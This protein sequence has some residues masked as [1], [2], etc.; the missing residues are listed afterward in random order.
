VGYVTTEGAF[1]KQEIQSYLQTK[2][3]EYMVP[4][5]WVELTTIPLTTNG[6]VDRKALPEPELTDLSKTYTAPSNETEQALASTW[7]ELLGREH[8]GIYD[9][10]FEIGGHSLLAMR[11]VSAIRKALNVEISVRDIFEH[12][13][14]AALGRHLGEQAKGTL[15]PAITSEERPARIPLSFSQERLWFIDKLEGS[16]QYHLPSVLRLRGEVN[17]PAL[18]TT[19][20]RIIE[21]HEVLRTVILADEQGQGYQQVMPAEGWKLSYEDQTQAAGNLE[22]HLQKL[23]SAPFDLSADYMLRAGLIRLGRDEYILAATMHH[24][25]SD[26]WSTSILVKEVVAL[27]GAYIEDQPAQLEALPIQYADYAIWQRKYMQGELLEA[28]LNYWKTKLAATAPLQLPCDNSRPAM[29]SSRGATLNFH[30]DQ[31]L[32]AK[33]GALS[34]QHGATLY[35]TLL[36]VFKVLLYRYSGQEDICV[37]TPIAG[38]N[39]HEVEGLI[40]FF[41]NTL[42]LRDQ[43]RGEDSF[44]VLLDQ[45]KETTLEAYAHQEVPFEKVVDAVVKDRDLG[46]HPLFQVMFVLQNTPEV[47]ELKLG[48]LQLASEGHEQRTTQFD[49]SFLLSETGTGLVG[50]VEYATDLYGED[51]IA[52]MTGHYINLLNSVAAAPETAAGKLSMLSVE[53]EAALNKFNDTKSAYPNDKHII[54]LFEE[55]AAQNPDAVA[56]VFEEENLTYKALNERSNQLARYLQKR[57]V[58]A[59]TLVPIC[60]ERSLE[61]IIGILGILKA[62]GAYVPIDPE[63]PQDRINYMLEDTEAELM[64]SSRSGRAKLNKGITIIALDGDGEAI[65]KEK[66]GNLETVISADQLAYVIYT[67]GSTGRPKGVMIEHGSLL[68]YCLTFK[69][70][71]AISDKDKILQQSSVSF[72]TMVEEVYPGLISG[73]SMIIVKEGGRDIYTLRNKIENEGISILSSTPTVIDWLNKELTT[74]GRLRYIISGGEVLPPHYINNLYSKVPIVNTYG[75]SESTVCVTYNKIDELASASLIGKPIANTQV[76]I[77]NKENELA[78]MG[79]TGEL[80]VGGVQVARGYLNNPGLT[81]EKFIKDPFS[82]E[83]GAKL[84]RTGD[85]AKW[86]PDGTIVYQGR[87]DDQVKIRGYRIELGE[88]ESV[89]N[90]HNNIRQGVV[91][92]KADKQGNNRLI[93]YVVA[94]GVF[95]KQAIQTFLNTRLPEYMVP[96]IWVELEAI[97]L[98]PNGKIDRKALPDPDLTAQPIEY[99]APRNETEQVLAAIWQELL[100]V[101]QVGIYDNFFELGGYSLLAM[102]VVSA[103]RNVL[104][105]EINVRDIFVN[106]SIAELATHLKANNKKKL[107]A[108]TPIKTSGNKTPLYIICGAGG[109]VFKFREFANLLDQDQ[110]VYGLQQF[111]DGED[112]DEF[113]DTI[114][115]VAAEYIEEIL[116]ENPDGPYALSG[117]CLGGTIAFEMANQ[118]KA[119]GKKV[120]LLAMFDAN[121]REQ[122]TIEEQEEIRPSLKN[123]YFIPTTIKAIIS[124]ISVKIRFELFLLIKHPKVAL[125]YKIRSIPPLF[126]YPE[127]AQEIIDKDVFD[128]LTD[129]L[130]RALNT[131]ELK[132]YYGEIL[133]FNAMKDYFFVDTENKILYKELPVNHKAKLAW[134]KHAESI[135]SYDVEGEH[136]TIFEPENASNFAEILQKHLNESSLDNIDVPKENAA[137]SKNL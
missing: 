67:S 123:F 24:I 32:S 91:V 107:R 3:P 14:I 65:N 93:G 45:V 80:C 110:P 26:G 133:L 113:P 82:S 57:G 44:T 97:P 2:L 108:L 51:T 111:I 7:Q 52:R 94:E 99:T 50:T 129:K 28:K 41:I 42:V 126:A 63:Y 137:V 58:K 72:D 27:Y 18:E 19:L 30:I 64:I 124:I 128:K 106:P 4:Q 33:L 9:N 122:H 114:E 43:V 96:A 38:R 84:Y 115:G 6:K 73:A 23:I 5:I 10:F 87:I 48:K 135:K 36:S 117:H 131:Y 15:L 76:Y 62:G 16:V 81:S 40:G 11:V 121:V 13:T 77:L 12:G 39:R 132:S 25:A 53:E 118:L 66:T 34:H 49:I 60:V 120:T 86:Q 61:M 56:I 134:K 1:D 74:T 78:P 59:E 95:D 20:Q 89:L 103:I 130:L 98:T 102:R 136:S 116:S 83:P 21:R 119:K 35:M 85:L 92:V 75:P 127:K 31:T 88:I 100:R 109:T 71:Y 37:G 8:I 22:E 112:P 101:E 47:P 17:V 69:S 29:Q 79:V 70:Y 125:Q 54:G 90:E 55:Q 46:R 104:N 68:N 105:A